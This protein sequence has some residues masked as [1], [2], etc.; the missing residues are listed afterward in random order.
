MYA[1]TDV[2]AKWGDNIELVCETRDMHTEVKW[3]SGMKGVA[4]D[5]HYSIKQY[6]Y[7]HRLLIKDV[8][9]TDDGDVMAVAGSDKVSIHIAV[10]GESVTKDLHKNGNTWMSFYI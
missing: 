5:D 6:G 1:T 3:F 4:N 2:S 10:V 7:S 8:R 9:P